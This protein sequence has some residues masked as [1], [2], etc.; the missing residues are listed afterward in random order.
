M[1]VAAASRVVALGVWSGED[2]HQRITLKISSNGHLVF[3]NAAGDNAGQW[4]ARGGDQFTVMIGGS[5]GVFTMLD[6]STATLKI[7]GATV[8]MRRR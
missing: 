3:T 8:E 4:E 1:K 7:G 6:Q 2:K 5:T